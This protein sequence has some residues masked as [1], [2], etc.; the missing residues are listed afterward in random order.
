MS[1]LRYNDFI[2]L[3]ESF[4]TPKGLKERALRIPLMIKKIEN[5]EPFTIEGNKMFVVTDVEDALRQIEEFKKTDIP[6]AM[7]FTGR[8]DGVPGQRVSTSKFVKTKEFGGGGGSRGGAQNTSLTESAQCYFCSALVNVIKNKDANDSDFTKEVLVSAGKWVFATESID[9]ILEKLTLDWR[10]SCVETAKQLMIKGFIKEGMNF[11]RGS[12]F[13][14]SIYESGKNAFNTIKDIPWN[15]KNDKWNPGDIW[16]V[17]S[18]QEQI[19]SNKFRE[20]NNKNASIA[21]FN[22]YLKSVFSLKQLLGISLKKIENPSSLK[23]EIN[24]DPEI[25]KQKYEVVEYRLSTKDFWSANKC[26][27]DVKAGNNPILK[28]EGRAFNLFENWALEIQGSTAA[29][30]KCGLAAI[31]NYIQNSNVNFY[32]FPGKINPKDANNKVRMR[33]NGLGG[34]GE[35]YSEIYELYLKIQKTNKVKNME[36]YSEKEFKKKIKEKWTD[37][38]TM[39][40]VFSKYAGMLVIDSLT[41]LN[42]HSVETDIINSIVLFAT[43]NT[44]E[45]SIFLKVYE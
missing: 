19:I 29:G 33:L 13:F 21:E 11:H 25:P 15:W 24:N 38:R 41:S 37:G 39:P 1:L 17:D 2:R 43:S 34:S 9:T 16:A 18:S 12:I 42:N 30:G 5:S 32:G 45:S 4:L 28:L 27:I 7:I 44:A 35:L 22:Q 14:N 31:L 10:T 40:W 6:K 20:M 26:F 36:P 8:I 23:I 3:N